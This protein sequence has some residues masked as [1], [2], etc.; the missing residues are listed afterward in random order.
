MYYRLWAL[1]SKTARFAIWTTE[2]NKYE[3]SLLL[4][5]KTVCSNPHYIDDF[6]SNDNCFHCF[7][8]WQRHMQKLISARKSDNL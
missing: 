4:A 3:A 8:L 1:Y 7:S 6:K 2:T 5:T